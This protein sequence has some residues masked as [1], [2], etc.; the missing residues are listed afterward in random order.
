MTLKDLLTSWDDNHLNLHL[1]QV[2][3]IV[4]FSK[5]DNC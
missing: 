5:N 2:T 4:E 1:R 3:V